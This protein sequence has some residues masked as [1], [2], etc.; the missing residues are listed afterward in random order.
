MKIKSKNKSITAL[1]LTVVLSSACSD[2]SRSNPSKESAEENESSVEHCQ[3]GVD[4]DSD[5]FVDCDDQDCI[6]FAICATSSDIHNSDGPFADLDT[7]GDSDADSQSTGSNVDVDSDSDTDADVNTDADTTS[8]PGTEAVTD[9]DVDTDGPT[10]GESDRG[11]DTYRVG[12][13]NDN[14]DSTVDL[15]TDI[16]TESRSDTDIE[17]NS[18]VATNPV[19]GENLFYWNADQFEST[20]MGTIWEVN[21]GATIDTDEKHEGTGS[22]RLVAEGDV[23]E[24]VGIGTEGPKLPTATMGTSLY[25]RWWMKMSPSYSWGGADKKMKIARVKQCTEEHPIAWTLYMSKDGVIHGGCSQ[26]VPEDPI[27]IYN[28]EPS[29]NPAVSD[30]HEYI[31]QIKWNNAPAADGEFRFFIDG[32]EHGQATTGMIFISSIDPDNLCEA[33]GAAMT[34][35]YPQLN[36]ASGG[37]VIWVDDISLDT[38]F[39]SNY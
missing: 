9:V 26:C 10:D 23:Q 1:S 8:G 25:Y 34:S 27:I 11:S 2:D 13:S 31:I 14:S 38:G 22:M 35:I 3:D 17:D 28:F 4:N 24:P 20:S 6:I 7:D 32:V 39:N 37:G 21:A 33:W 19:E 30:W 5:S 18:E 15:N 12:D 16:D 36:D 29:E